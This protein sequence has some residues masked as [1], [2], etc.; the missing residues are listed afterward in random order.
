VLAALVVRVDPRETAMGPSNRIWLGDALVEGQRLSIML[1]GGVVLGASKGDVAEAGKAL[2]AKMNG[3]LR[4][5]DRRRLFERG[6]RSQTCESGEFAE[7]ESRVDGRFSLGF[8][9]R[10]QDGDL[11]VANFRC[12]ARDRFGTPFCPGF[13]PERPRQAQIV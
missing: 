8:V 10:S 5:R 2:G 3:P 9:E 11:D 1:A 13:F 4:L 7:A 12:E 6:G